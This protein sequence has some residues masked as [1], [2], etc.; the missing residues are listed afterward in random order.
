[1]FEKFLA[2]QNIQWQNKMFELGYPRQIAAELE[3]LV[4]LKQIIALIGIRRSGKSTVAKQLISHLIT[5][6]KVKPQNI[7]FL[8][9]ESPSLNSYKDDPNNLQ[10]IFEEYIVLNNP[11]GRIYVF[12]DEAQFFDN[13]QVFVK[14]LYEKGN[15]KFFITGSNSKLLSAEM[16]TMLSGRSIAKNIHPFSF[17]EIIKIN[18]LKINK[19]LD[20]YVNQAKIIR[21]FKD[22]FRT[23]GFPEVVLEKRPEIRQEILSNYYKNI[24][25]QDIVPRFEIKKT[26]EIENLLLYLF[27]NIGQLYSYNSLGKFLKISDKTAREYISFFEKSFLMFEVYNYQYSLK[28]QENYPKKI[29]AVDNGFIDA[30]SFSFSENYDHFLENA[31]FVKL[32]EA[33]EKVYYY[34]NKTECDFI[35][36]EKTKIRAAIQV[37]KMIDHHNEKREIQGLLDAMGRFKL[38]RGLIITENQEDEKKFNN[39]TIKIM[40]IWKW[41]LTDQR[42]L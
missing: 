32:L 40:P 38:N 6:K 4:N 18:N 11:K 27:S 10:K 24:L 36:K 15:V 14:D 30:A 17:E 21:L 34:K 12:L 33:N 42:L 23:G 9:L 35:I 13:W 7:L 29:Y 5:E 20:I 16:A 41:L 39:Q 37:A 31:V 2:E 22:Y 8:N 3:K 25:Y 28:K 26:K 1:M 19:K